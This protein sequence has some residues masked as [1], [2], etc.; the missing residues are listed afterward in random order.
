[1]F[2]AMLVVISAVAFTQFA[3][4]YWRAVL[5]GAAAQPVS[6]RVLDSVNVDGDSS[7]RQ[8]FPGLG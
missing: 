5:T 7:Y 3:I 4:Y 6:Q 2:A 1:M 8:A